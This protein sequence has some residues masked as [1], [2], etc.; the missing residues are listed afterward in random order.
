[1]SMIEGADCVIKCD[2]TGQIKCITCKANNYDYDGVNEKAIGY[3][4]YNHGACHIL[5]MLGENSF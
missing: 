3:R 1:M 2:K 5:L 4:L